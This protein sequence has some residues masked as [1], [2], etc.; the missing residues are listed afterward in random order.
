MDLIAIIGVNVIQHELV[1]VVINMNIL[2]INHDF[3]CITKDG[4]QFLKRN[5]FGFWEHKVSP[6]DADAADDYENLVAVLVPGFA[7]ND[8]G[9]TYEIEL[10]SDIG[11]CRSCRLEIYEIG[12]GNRSNG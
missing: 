10:P 12:Q 1:R 2:G 6:Y 9:K 4:G 7:G 5:T 8:A 11:K 3:L